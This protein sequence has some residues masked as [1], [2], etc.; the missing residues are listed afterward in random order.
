MPEKKWELI[1]I[2]LDK[3]EMSVYHKVLIFSQTLFAQF[4][5]QRAEKNQDYLDYKTNE[6][7]GSSKA[8]NNEYFKMRKRLLKLNKVKDVSSHEILVLLLRLRQICCHPSLITAMLDD[9]GEDVEDSEDEKS[10]H[11]NLLDQLEKLNI[12]DDDVYQSG[13]S[14]SNVAQ[15]ISTEDKITLKEASKGHLRASDPVFTKERASSKVKVVLKVLQERVL[16]N[17]DKAILVSQWPTYLKLIAMHLHSCDVQFEQLDGSVPV[18]KRMDIVDRLNDPKDNLR[19]L[20]L[21]LTAGGVGLNLVGANHLFLMDLHW[22]PQL[23]NQAQDR[24]YRVGQIKP[25]FVYKFMAT[26]TIEERI[27]A[28]QD[29]KLAM[30]E[31]ILTG[32]KQAIQSKLTIDDLRMIFGM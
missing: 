14:E 18:H 3:N 21:S 4:L 15:G 31:G 13:Q 26:D 20:L 27:K 16:S 8:P 12:D 7:V 9:C 25:V 6:A 32:T 30:A 17:G 24:I 2:E 5:H 22:N 29:K 11:L 28:L 23:E 1:K 10:D 19:V